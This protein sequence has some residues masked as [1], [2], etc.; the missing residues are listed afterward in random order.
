MKDLD[1][2]VVSGLM[3]VSFWGPNGSQLEARWMVPEP[4][5]TRR[6]EAT[7][8]ASTGAALPFLALMSR[9]FLRSEI[10]KDPASSVAE[11]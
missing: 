4:S 11:V 10:C 1:S 3:T 2:G 7:D 5:L 9:V 6:T 8:P